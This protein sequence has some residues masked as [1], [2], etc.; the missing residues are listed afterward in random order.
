MPQKQLVYRNE[1]PWLQNTHLL[2]AVQQFLES[3]ALIQNYEPSLTTFLL[4]ALFRQRY[5]NQILSLTQLSKLCMEQ[6]RSP[7]SALS[8]AVRESSN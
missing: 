6:E 4:R 3:E 7:P 8:V 5:I 2:G 1:T